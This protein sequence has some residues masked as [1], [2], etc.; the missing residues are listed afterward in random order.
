MIDV[1]ASMGLCG[2]WGDEPAFL[3]T[4]QL[5]G[6]TL[7]K[8]NKPRAGGAM[9]PPEVKRMM[10]SANALTVVQLDV[11]KLLEVSM[12]DLT[13]GREI[14]VA[15][16]MSTKKG[17]QVANGGAKKAEGEMKKGEGNG[18]LEAMVD[19]EGAGI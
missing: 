14:F 18:T 11:Y 2:P 1:R 13:E 7:L 19:A 16:D 8:H 9:G 5:F 3:E 12:Q 10:G 4:Y 15:K 17:E 6:D